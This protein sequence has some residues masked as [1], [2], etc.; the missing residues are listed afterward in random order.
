MHRPSFHLVLALALPGLA[1]V[2]QGPAATK[3]EETFLSRDTHQGVSIAAKPIPDTP[4]AE[5]IFGPNAAPTRAGF[6]PVE[7][8]IRNDREESIEVALG[9]IIVVS[10]RE[11]FEQAGTKT[12]ALW[13]YPPPG[14]KEPKVGGSRLPIPWPSGP[15]VAKDKKRAEREEA[16]ASL[17]SRQLRA[18]KV[19]PGAH[20][21]GF[22]YFDLRDAGI[23][24]TQS[25][26]YVPEVNGVDSG[27]GLL[28]FE[29]SLEA[30]ARP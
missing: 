16:E 19:A 5:C 20:A 1:L 2:A 21:R 3:D 15:K 6:L 26:V 12:V 13:M 18:E 4:E 17:R 25:Y 24:L 9:R 14:V 10:G 11:E 22:L 23:D 7:L 30:Y 27:E 8:L 28:F 29:V